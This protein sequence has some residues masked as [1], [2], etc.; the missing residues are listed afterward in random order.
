MTP[1]L[2]VFGKAM[3]GGLPLSCLAGRADIMDAITRGEVG[4][5]GTFNANPVVIAAAGAALRMI[6]EHGNALYEPVQARGQALAGGIAE[7]ARR[8]GVDVLVN[9]A[10]TVFQTYQTTLPAVRDYREF[11]QCDAERTRACHLALLDSGVNIVA[12]GLWFL[13]TE[14]DDA[15]VD[16]TLDAVDLALDRVS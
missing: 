16:M 11:A 12:R 14:H 3:A 1:D 4:H 8:H 13:S 2:A 10:G 15:D 6:R 5:A 7:R 9:G